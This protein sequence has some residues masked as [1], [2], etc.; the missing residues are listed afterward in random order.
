MSTGTGYSTTDVVSYNS[1]QVVLQN[2]Q[3][4]VETTSEGQRYQIKAQTSVSTS[5]SPD[6][7][8]QR[9]K[10]YLTAPIFIEFTISEIE[11]ITKIQVVCYIKTNYFPLIKSTII[12]LPIKRGIIAGIPRRNAANDLRKILAHLAITEFQ[13]THRSPKALALWAKTLGIMFLGYLFVIT[14]IFLP[15]VIGLIALIT[16]YPEIAYGFLIVGFFVGV[17]FIWQLITITRK[18][19]G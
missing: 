7:I 3:D 13:L 1:K 4:W 18:T 6:L 19:F 9:G 16:G 11:N 14:T 17:L 2:I 5:L 15:Y 10:G 12:Q 8:L